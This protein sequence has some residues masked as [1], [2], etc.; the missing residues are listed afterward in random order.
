MFNHH[1]RINNLLKSYNNFQQHDFIYK[2]V[3][4]DIIDRISDFQINFEIILD[5]MSMGNY[6]DK[7][8]SKELIKIRPHDIK[9][10]YYNEPY[11]VNLFIYNLG[12]HLINDVQKFII[13]AKDSIEENGIFIAT[14]FG[15]KTLHELRKT[16]IEYENKKDGKI[17]SH[18]IPMITVQD[19]V[20]LMQS[21]G[22]K[23]TIVDTYNIEVEYNNTLA[24]MRDIKSMGQ[25]NC[26]AN[27]ASSILYKKPLLNGEID[28]IYKEKFGS[29]IAS[30]EIITLTGFK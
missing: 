10:E 26:L 3:A 15:G 5:Y 28:Y 8:K 21:S 1:H 13:S 11:K 4:D 17:M 12:L 18:I 22:F 16:L 6:F 2:M 14:I 20:R 25:S 7:F 27:R 19:S 29:C 9:N 24:L 23:S 30:F